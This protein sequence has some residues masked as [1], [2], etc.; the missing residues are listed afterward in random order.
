MQAGYG[1]TPEDRGMVGTVCIDSLGV[2]SHHSPFSP[3]PCLNYIKL[4]ISYLLFRERTCKSRF[5][6]VQRTLM[7]EKMVS[8]FILM[9]LY[10]QSHMKCT[11]KV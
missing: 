6:N 11:G 10:C 5:L 8:A 2:R 9:R 7:Q 4:G 1:V 3:Y